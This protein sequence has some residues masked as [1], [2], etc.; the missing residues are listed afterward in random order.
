VTATTTA[1]IAPGDAPSARPVSVARAFRFELVK[2]LAQWRV[3]LLILACLIG[4]ALAVIL[5]SQQVSLPSDTLFGRQMHAT[6]WAGA[7]VVLSFAG[8]WFFPLLTSVVAGDVFSAEDRLGTWRHLLVAVRSPRRI[9]VAKALASLTV[10]LVCVPG[11]AVSGIVGGLV[12]GSRP[13]TGLDGH[14]LSPAD[15]A[16]KLLL[17]WLCALAPILAF[18][19]I[20]LLASV[21]FGRSPI[22]L[23]L[24]AFGGLGMQMAS[25]VLPMPV[26]V[27]LAL[28]S[29]AFLSWNGLFTSPQ[30]LGPL[31]TGIAVSLA[32]AVTAT[33]LAYVLFMRRDFTSLAND[34][35]MR[36]AITFGI[37]PLLGVWALSA[38]VVAAATG[39]TGSGIDAGQLQRSLAT[40]FA[41]LY[42]LQSQEVNHLNVTEAQLRTTASCTKGSDLVAQD[43]PGN[44]WRC[45]VYWHLPGVNDATGQAVYQLDV[46]A[47]GRYVADGDGPNEVNG[48]FVVHASYGDAPNP[49]WQFD[50]LVDL[51]ASTSKGKP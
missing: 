31:L 3:R 42:R 24:P 20:G 51:L 22:G 49:L 10:L 39:A 5:V 26:A 25:Q 45:Y 11:L 40:S 46:N 28:P 17:A 4:P 33:A 47:N 9:F 41:H 14:L 37:L 15:A 13:L 12:V 8:S 48:Y 6:G 18:A 2:Q 34:G 43:G 44:D 1:P 32:W 19:A 35:S 23:L 50:G 27:R 21:I 29:F 30:I 38:G 16:G 36:R 7:L